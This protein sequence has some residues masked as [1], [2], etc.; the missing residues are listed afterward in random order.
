MAFAPYVPV[1]QRRAQAAREIEKL[2]KKGRT[3]APVVIEGRNDRQDLLGQ[4]LVRKSGALFRFRKP[5]AARKN[6]C[7][8]WFGRRSPGRARPNPR[9]WS[10]LQPLQCE[11]RYRRCSDRALGG[12]LQ[13]LRWLGRLAGGIAVRANCR[14]TSWSASAAKA[15]ACFRRRR[16]QMSCSCPDWARMCKHVAAVLY[17]VG[18]RL[19]ATPDLLFAL[20][21]VDSSELIA[22]AGADLPITH[23]GGVGTRILA[24]DDLAALF[25]VEMAP[26]AATPKAHDVERKARPTKNAASSKA[27]VTGQARSSSPTTTKTS[28]T[29][30]STIVSSATA[31]KS[32]SQKPRPQKAA[33]VAQ[34]SQDRTVRQDDK[35][36]GAP[37]RPATSTSASARQRRNAFTTSSSHKGGEVDKAPMNCRIPAESRRSLAT[38][39]DEDA[40]IIPVRAM[41]AIQRK[42]PMPIGRNSAQRRPSRRRPRRPRDTR[43]GALTCLGRNRYSFRQFTF[44]EYDLTV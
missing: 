29:N 18:A 38:M 30:G 24:D 22:N 25:G 14:R 21:G 6:L 34:S 10:G 43:D 16:N 15:T 9:D 27:P 40:P 13:G 8:Q 3:I 32:R 7:P 11:D 41:A 36:S 19:D 42:Q 23:S 28:T 26:A 44:F 2:R 4:G 39:K 12:D 31:G 37:K 5:P 17:G 35:L 20:R 33:A 1:A